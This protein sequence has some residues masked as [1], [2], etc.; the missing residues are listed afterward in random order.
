M[1]TITRRAILKTGLLIAG[2]TI[3]ATSTTAVRETRDIQLVPGISSVQLVP[4]Q[5]PVTDTWCYNNFVPGPELRVQQGDRLRVTCK[6][7]LGESTT[8]HWHGV[9]LSNN[10]DGVPHLT[11][12][13]IQPGEEFVYEFDAVDAGTFWYHPHQRSAEQVG[14]G[15]YGTFIVEEPEPI[16]VD[17]EITW[18]LDDWRLSRDAQIVDDFD[19]RHDLS[20]NGRIGNTVTINGRV[21]GPFEVQAGER[22]RLRLVNAANARIFALDFSPLEARIIAIDGQPVTPHDS[23]GNI[24]LAPAMRVDVVLDMTGKPGDRYSVVD[25]YYRDFNYALVDLLY[26]STSKRINLLNSPIELTPNPV[27]EPLLENAV[28]YQIEFDGGA[29]SPMAGAV[30][31]G[32]WQDMR[33][34]VHSGKFWA[35]NGVTAT[36]HVMEPLISLYQGQ[37]AVLDLRNNTAWPH[38]MHLHGHSFRV[39]SRNGT[40]TLHREWQDTVLL[41]AQENAEIA[42]VADN[43]GD[44][45]FH[46]HILEHQASGMMGVIR[47]RTD[48]A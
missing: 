2:G 41:E 45:M 37:T 10:M 14:R 1:A 16:Q 31:D 3:P 17:R 43:P 26:T 8:I 11:Q 39:L 27:P 13:P 42:F 6:N 18:V 12:T 48:R 34:M 7:A 30:L 15:L 38:P 21:P 36:G 46:C 25:R 4:T 24:V 9:R 44:W 29:M 32:K 47:V 20:H 33:N 23:G 28:H 5:Y 22:V 19:N 40:P 35:I